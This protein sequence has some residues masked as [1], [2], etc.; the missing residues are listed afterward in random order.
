MI[1]SLPKLFESRYASRISEYV[2]PPATNTSSRCRLS[3]AVP[4]PRVALCQLGFW[5]R[6]DTAGDG[7]GEGDAPARRLLAPEPCTEGESLTYGK[8]VGS[9]LFATCSCAH[10]SR[11]G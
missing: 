2:T 6:G 7:D 8:S 11:D 9:S 3:F 1:T 4:A 5:L 10:K